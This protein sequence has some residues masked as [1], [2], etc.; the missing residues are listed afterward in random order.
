MAIAPGMSA[1][2]SRK[3]KEK[4]TATHHGNPGVEV[5]STP[6]LCEWV[7]E[8]ACKAVHP[9]LDPGMV[10]VGTVVNLKHLAATP[11]GMT[12]RVQA[13]LTEVDGR[14]LVFVVEA[15][16]EKEKIGESH[17]ERFIVTLQR[18]LERTAQKA[19]G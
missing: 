19:R 11:V 17:Q 14:R 7:E 6:V 5:F 9:H 12:V 1:E 4:D 18:F 3:V 13:R 10:T 2:F 16:D 8:A 15:F